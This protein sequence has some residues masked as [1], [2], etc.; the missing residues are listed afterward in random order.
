MFYGG[1]YGSGL[2]GFQLG[3]RIAPAITSSASVSVAENLALAHTLTASETV[4]WSIV[5]GADQ[6]HFELNGATLRFAANGTKDFEAPDDANADN[7]YVVTVRATDSLGN[8]A[9]Q[10]VTATVTNALEVT[11]GALTLDSLTIA[12]DQIEGTTVGTI[13]GATAGSTVTLLTQSN[14]GMFAKD[15]DDIEVGATPLDFET[16]PS[17]TITLRETHPDASNSPNDTVITITV[18]DVGE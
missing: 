5:G 12:E 8:T 6:A 16:A 11:L 4:T 1:V 9:D 7:A 3:D 18:T 2:G 17:P 15:G 13:T 14:A 10:A